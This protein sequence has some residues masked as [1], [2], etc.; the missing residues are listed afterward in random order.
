MNMCYFHP[1]NQNK[2]KQKSFLTQ[3]YMDEIKEGKYYNI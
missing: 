2:Q 1:K 3:Y